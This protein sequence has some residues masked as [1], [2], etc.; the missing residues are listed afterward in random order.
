MIRYGSTLC[1]NRDMTKL[2]AHILLFEPTVMRM[3]P[4]MAKGLYNR[5][6][7]MSRQQPGKSLFQIKEEVLGKRLRKVVSGGG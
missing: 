4:M 1:L 2:A 7:I 6:A 5:I 3:V